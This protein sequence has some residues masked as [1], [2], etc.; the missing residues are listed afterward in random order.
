MKTVHPLLIALSLIFSLGVL[1]GESESS[2]KSHFNLKK[3]VAIQGYDP[4]TYFTKGAAIKG[5][6][7][8]QHTHNGITYH[9]SSEATKHSFLTNPSKY[10]PQY[11]GWCAY[12]LAKGGGK[13]KIHPKRFKIINDKLYLFFDTAVWGNTLKKWN[14]SSDKTQVDQADATWQKLIN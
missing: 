9:F 3:G 5:N 2:R 6:S 1:H 10:E 12:A 11:G 4:V 13:V 8:F 14:D 7:K